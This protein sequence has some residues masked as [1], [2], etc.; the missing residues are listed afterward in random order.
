MA[1]GMEFLLAALCLNATCDN[2]GQPNMVD[3][4]ELTVDEYDIKSV[5]TDKG[6]YFFN[7]IHFFYY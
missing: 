2:T 4:S 6:S 3:V 7:L 5:Y 1:G